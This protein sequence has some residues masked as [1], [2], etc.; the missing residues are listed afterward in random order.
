MNFTASL[1][2]ALTLQ[3]K[4]FEGMAKGFGNPS[5]VV[6][7]L[8][9]NTSNS[10]RCAVIIGKVEFGY[11]ERGTIEKKL[12][13]SV[14]IARSLLPS[15]ATVESLPRNGTITTDGK[16]FKINTADQNDAYLFLTA[17]HWAATV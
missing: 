15:W 1:N 16:V 2:K 13:C 14:S 6:F 11:N 3:N 10:I 12:P 4:A 8:G 9:S 17:F 7:T 5:S